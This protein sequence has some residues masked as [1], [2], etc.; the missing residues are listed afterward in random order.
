MKDNY[1]INLSIPTP[2]HCLKDAGLNGKCPAMKPFILGKKSEAVNSVCQEHWT[3][4]DWAK[5]CEL[6]SRSSTYSL[7]MV[8][9][10]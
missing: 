8:C 4:K 2:E 9:S 10:M 1:S 3:S 7:P 5:C 6:A